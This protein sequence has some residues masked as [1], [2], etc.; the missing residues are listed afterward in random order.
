MRRNRPNDQRTATVNDD[1]ASQNDAA[2]V[3]SFSQ[4]A[5][6]PAVPDRVDLVRAFQRV[7]ESGGRELRLAWE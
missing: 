3:S 4:Q 5:R 6:P 2:G 1:S 7:E